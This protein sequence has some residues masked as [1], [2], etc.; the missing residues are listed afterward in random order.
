MRFGGEFRAK[1]IKR[2]EVVEL[3]PT[4]ES[5]KRRQGV[6]VRLH[7]QK[8]AKMAD[9]WGPADRVF[10]YSESDSKGIEIGYFNDRTKERITL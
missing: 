8:A 6:V 7:H 5:G 9:G 3:L 2:G 10:L 1:V 4:D